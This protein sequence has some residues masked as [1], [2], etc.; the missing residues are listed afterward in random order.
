MSNHSNESSV[1]LITG[2]SS[3]LGRALAE[4]ALERGHR[5]AVTAR[6]R[7]SVTDLAAKYGDRALA[8]RL[9]VTDPASV[10]AAV[11]TCEAEFGRIDVL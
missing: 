1:W 9:D 7:A 3:G 5:V 4:H 8:L 10:S 2:C 6:N 11:Q